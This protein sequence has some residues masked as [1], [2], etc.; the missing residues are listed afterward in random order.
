MLVQQVLR[1]WTSCHRGSCKETTWWNGWYRPDNEI[2]LLPDWELERCANW[3]SEIA[4]FTSSLRIHWLI[5][6]SIKGLTQPGCLRFLWRVVD[7]MV[8]TEWIMK[9]T[10]S[11][12][13]HMCGRG[14]HSLGQLRW[15]MLMSLLPSS[16]LQ[17]R[18]DEMVVNGWIKN[19]VTSE[20]CNA[21]GDHEP[22]APHDPFG[23]V[24]PASASAIGQVIINYLWILWRDHYTCLTP[25]VLSL[26]PILAMFG[27]RPLYP[28]PKMVRDACKGWY[29][30]RVPA[31][32]NPIWCSFW[33]ELGPK[34]VLDDVDQSSAVNKS[35]I[36]TTVW[37]LLLFT[38][39]ICSCRARQGP[40]AAWGA[41]P[42]D[43]GVR[44]VP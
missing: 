39:R 34:Y 18:I 21:S 10:Y 44:I 12:E 9:S 23:R 32:R 17:R 29:G 5:G 11:L 28:P 2:N 41:V 16:L 30:N 4:R 27:L 43:I 7:E 20:F 35:S 25:P 42:T 31:W 22:G 24:F 15:Q 33:L 36:R 19:L 38:C 13:R 37:L 6:R 14:R 1:D 8:D 3:T 40:V 26:A